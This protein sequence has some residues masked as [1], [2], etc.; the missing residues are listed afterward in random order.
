L[1]V[2]DNFETITDAALL[3]WLLDLPEPSKALMTTR[4]YRREFRRGGWPV[5]LRGMSEAEAFALVEERLRLLRIDRLAHNRAQLDPLIAITGGNPKAIEL[6]LGLIK[7]ER[8]S[9]RQVIDDL[10]AARGDL[11]ADLFVRAWALLDEASQHGL[12]A[13]SLFPIS[14]SGMALQTVAG[15]SG[16]LFER[17]IEQLADL[18]LIDLQQFDLNSPPRYALH[19]LVRAFAGARLA[20]HPAFERSA[21][22]R[23]LAWY[24]EIAATTEA[25]WYDTHALAVI[26]P[27]ADNLSAVVTWAAQAGYDTDVLRLSATLGYYYYVRGWWSEQLLING[28]RLATAQRLGNRLEE[29]YTILNMLRIMALQGRITEARS[30]AE[31][32]E[33]ILH[34]VVQ[35]DRQ[36][37][38]FLHSLA[39][40]AFADGNIEH[41]RSLLREVMRLCGNTDAYKY[42]RARNWLADSLLQAGDLAE[43]ERLFEESLAE[44]LKISYYRSATFCQLKLALAAI[45]R[46]DDQRAEHLLEAALQRATT[47]QDRRDL[48]IIKQ[49]YAQLYTLRGDTLAAQVAL[50]EAID[51][52]ERLGMRREL[53]EARRRAAEHLLLQGEG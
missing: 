9:L 32:V 39:I 16:Y 6:A 5:E 1:V 4:E 23:W 2:V 53:G 17:A 51:L 46:G 13:M 29:G 24:L 33:I 28:V 12:L 7:Y 22:E 35:T 10:H 38:S 43:A 36:R 15:V 3:A 41:G 18:A 44:S 48:A 30:L 20:E 27:E 21:R 42:V 8:R 52:F 49:T 47:S 25:N 11:F 45:Q 40:F 34:V 31:Q 14:A 19:P 26:D 37:C 50:A